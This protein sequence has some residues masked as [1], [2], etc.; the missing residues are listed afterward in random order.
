MKK[1]RSLTGALI[2]SSN[3]GFFKL[4]IFIEDAFFEP[5][6]HDAEITIKIGSF[7]KTFHF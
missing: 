4:I 6:E 2:F 1:W 5:L 3:E 7:Y